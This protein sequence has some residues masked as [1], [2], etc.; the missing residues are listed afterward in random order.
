MNKASFL[1]HAYSALVITASLALGYGINAVFDF[2]PAALYG[3]LLLT[4]GLQAELVNPHKLQASVDWIIKHMGVCFVPAGVGI[5]EHEAL[6]AEFGLV[7]TLLVILSTMTLLLVI[8]LLYQRQL[9]KQKALVD[10]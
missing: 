5:M 7:L 4:F 9:N 1:N 8:G 6:I 10:R 3:M 2:L